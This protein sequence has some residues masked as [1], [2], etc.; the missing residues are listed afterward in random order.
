MRDTMRVMLLLLILG[1]SNRDLVSEYSLSSILH[2]Y[3]L[4]LAE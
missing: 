1:V 4:C 3:L 2:V